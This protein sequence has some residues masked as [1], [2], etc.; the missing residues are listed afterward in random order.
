MRDLKNQEDY[1]KARQEIE[2]LK[3]QDLP[4]STRLEGNESNG[5]CGGVMLLVVSKVYNRVTSFSCLENPARR[6]WWCAATAGT[7][8]AVA[9]EP[10]WMLDP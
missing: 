7:S 5:R 4:A 10:G 6:R 8:P 2:R 3:T 9:H 1:Q